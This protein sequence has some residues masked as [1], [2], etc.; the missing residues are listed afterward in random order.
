MPIAFLSRHHSV[1]LFFCW[2]D[3]SFLGLVGLESW[4]LVASG[5]LGGT[6]SSDVGLEGL[7]F[8]IS[9][10][11]VGGVHS[12][13][14]S[15]EL[16]LGGNGLERVGERCGLGSVGIVRSIESDGRDG[17]EEDSNGIINPLKK[18]MITYLKLEIRIGCREFF[19]L[20]IDCFRFFRNKSD[21][22]LYLYIRKRLNPFF[23][24]S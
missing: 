11:H 3:C 13:V 4:V 7:A 12:K 20:K 8:G 24:Y 17:G 5:L 19:S 1:S 18:T 16:L 9:G 23:L 10:G 15:L 21:D 2:Y 14:V 6:G 22:Y